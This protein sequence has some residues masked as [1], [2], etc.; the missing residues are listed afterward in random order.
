MRNLVLFPF[1]LAL[2]F[3]CIGTPS[4]D[5]PRAIGV[6]GSEVVVEDGI[7]E[8]I[9]VAEDGEIILSG[10]QSGMLYTVYGNESNARTMS[11]SGLQY[12]GGGTYGFLLDEGETEAAFSAG[13]IGLRPGDDFRIGEKE[14]ED[15]TFIEGKSGFTF[16]EGITEPLFI[17]KNGSEVYEVFLSINVR[18]I[19][20]PSNI[21]VTEMISHTG[22]GGG[23]HSLAFVDEKGNWLDLDADALIDLR[24]YET[25][26]LWA[27][28]VVDY[29]DNGDMV[30]HI[31]L[32]NP[33]MMDENGFT[34]E[35]PG[36][37]MRGPSSA[38]EYLVIDTLPELNH[39]MG[40]FVNELDA[41][42][43]ESG[44]RF[45]GVYPLGILD[46]KLYI[47]LPARD[48][49]ILIDYDG[50]DTI[51]AHIE[52]NDGKIETLKM[53]RGSY[54][55]SIPSDTIFVTAEM[56]ED[57]PGATVS[58]EAEGGEGILYIF[59]SKADGNG[60]SHPIIRGNGSE[61]LDDDILIDALV[62]RNRSLTDLDVTLTIE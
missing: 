29:S 20:N 34:M 44:T 46:G 30:Q 48:E 19:E 47:N 53:R 22:Y 21:A 7:S 6:N 54:T 62:V 3:S 32:M 33:E 5:P 4:Q 17:D 55:F 27:Q 41:S 56:A 59:S 31:Y 35:N 26:Y 52:R 18:S 11:S 8:S 43:A 57:I 15:I 10:L 50:E 60:Y 36:V 39:G 25:I 1:V 51:P 37:Y 38:D 28:M 14:A 24:T 16:G 23:S 12:L 61:T 58:V 42:T 40:V 45:R 2:L 49:A 9:P 13:D